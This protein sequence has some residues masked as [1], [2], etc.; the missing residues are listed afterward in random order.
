[1]NKKDRLVDID[2]AKG[3]AIFLV[4]VGHI[5]AADTP[6]GNEWYAVLKF[7]I[8]KFH[9]PFF[10]F[11]SG[12][13][14]AY[15][16]PVIKNGEDYFKYIFRKLKRLVPGYVLFGAVIYIGKLA[17]SK[18]MHVDRL[19]GNV[20]SE[21]YN[22]L[23]VPSQS[24]GGSLWFIY[25]LMEMY[26]VFPLVMVFFIKRPVL[27]ILAGLIAEFMPVSNVLM[28]DRFCEYFIFFAI[29]VIVVQWYQEYL[30][31]IDRYRYYVIALFIMSFATVEFVSPLVSKII[32]GFFSLPAL[33]SMMRFTVDAT[34]SIWE[35]FGNYTYSIYLMNT[36]LIGLA[37]GVILM[38]F[39]WDGA[40]F[41]MI[42]PVL[43]LVGLFGPIFVKKY[44]FKYV[45]IL[46]SVTS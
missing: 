22:L 18:V 43:L 23:L 3:F 21:L 15:T 19:P 40:N 17:S 6:A 9:M 39:T 20:Y 5:V 45:P 29:G 28:L 30:N 7:Y 32:I 38:F 37:K 2:K 41:L 16:F 25:V 26:I 24:A 14:M 34:L 13:I 4:V 31:V 12:V 11:I 46:N 33:H 10:M 8:Y 42:S 1:M 44:I 35:I 27:I 36:I